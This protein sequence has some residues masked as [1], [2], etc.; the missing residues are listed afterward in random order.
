MEVLYPVGN[1]L[2]LYNFERKT[3]RIIPVGETTSD[4]ITCVSVS[5]NKRYVAVGFRG[6][7][8]S[9]IV[10]DLQ[11]MKKKKTLFPPEETTV[12]YNLFHI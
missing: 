4:V 3:Q 5:D 12:K 2:I 7:Q 11:M 6:N 10:F 8:A 1:S 9:S